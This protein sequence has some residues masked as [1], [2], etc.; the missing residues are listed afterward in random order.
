[1]PPFGPG[2]HPAQAPPSEVNRFWRR[3]MWDTE[4]HRLYTHLTQVTHSTDTHQNPLYLQNTFHD[5]ARDRAAQLQNKHLAK[6]NINLFRRL[7]AVH[8]RRPREF[9]THHVQ[10]PKTHSRYL[11]HKRVQDDNQRLVQ[12]LQQSKTF[13][14]ERGSWDE[15]AQEHE[16]MLIRLSHNPKSC[17]IPGLAAKRKADQA[18]M[19]TASIAQQAQAKIASPRVPLQKA[20]E[21]AARIEAG[22][23]PFDPQTDDRGSWTHTSSRSG[24]GFG[25]GS[26]RSRSP[27]RGSAARHARSRIGG[28]GGGG[29]LYSYP[30]PPSSLPLDPTD[31]ESARALSR[32]SPQLH[33]ARGSPPPVLLPYGT[34]LVAPAVLDQAQYDAIHARLQEAASGRPLTTEELGGEEDEGDDSAAAAAARSFAL[35]MAEG[36]IQHTML[37]LPFPA[38]AALDDDAEPQREIFFLQ[39]HAHRAASPDPATGS[40]GED[41][42]AAA[43]TEPTAAA[44]AS[45]SLVREAHAI[46]YPFQL[47]PLDLPE[48]SPAALAAQ[49]Q[50]EAA[51]AAARRGSQQQLLQDEKEEADGGGG[52]GA[53]HRH[54]SRP[55]SRPSASPAPP[56]ALHSH[57][58]AASGSGT[59]EPQPPA[60]A[61]AAS[62]SSSSVGGS[63]R[64]GR[65]VQLPSVSGAAA[66]AAALPAAPA[67]A[68][69]S[70]VTPWVHYATA[71]PSVYA[72]STSALKGARVGASNSL[73][74]SGG[75]VRPFA[76]GSQRR[77]QQEAIEALID[78]ACMPEETSSSSAGAGGSGS[79]LNKTQK[80]SQPRSRPPPSAPASHA[81]GA[82]PEESKQSEES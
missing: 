52:S 11:E 9:L 6:E 19:R 2:A 49:A 32:A 27:S 61:R 75:G 13:V 28:S 51:I 57:S 36:H 79:S 65:R 33:S 24:S 43:E 37:A 5:Q 45:K 38:P 82:R 4:L 54:Y 70:V 31:P 66:G 59:F 34:H 3:Q 48:G 26:D 17:F 20:M 39:P 8:T 25:G 67:T 10:N 71:R 18:S 29:P 55:S 46:P 14:N 68:T 53:L 72:H 42:T 78:L 64:G 1:M 60:I 73:A 56:A 41:N 44:T 23:I 12:R 63:S 21:R 30:L 50:R 7:M 16:E 35:A 62:A 40:V 69:H 15:H 22:E 74:T 80:R 58:R 77:T 81:T 76:P 47:P